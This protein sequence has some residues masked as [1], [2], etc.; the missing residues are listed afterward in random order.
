MEIDHVGL[1]FFARLH[2]FF[3]CGVLDIHAGNFAFA[4]IDAACGIQGER[5]SLDRDQGQLLRRRNREALRQH[6]ADGKAVAHDGDVAQ[7]DLALE[8]VDGGLGID[9]GRECSFHQLHVLFGSDGGIRINL[10]GFFRQISL[11]CED[12]QIDAVI[13]E[14]QIRNALRI[15]G[16]IDVCR[17]LDDIAQHAGNLLAG[18]GPGD[19]LG[20]GKHFA[21][22]LPLAVERFGQAREAAGGE[23]GDHQDRR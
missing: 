12:G 3:D 21:G 9:H 11:L 2:L 20:E 15:R 4:Q 17:V 14:A 18:F 5:R 23:D 16:K 1:N 8:D 13:L 22:G 19:F 7:I 10:R 6:R